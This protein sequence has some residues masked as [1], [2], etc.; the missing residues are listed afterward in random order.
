MSDHLGV[1]LGG[2]DV[3]LAF[4]LALEG[5][6][7]LDDAVVDHGQAIAGLVRVGIGFARRAMGGPAG[8]RD[9]DTALERSFLEA[10]LQRPDLAQRT[11]AVQATL[12][13]EDG[14]A[15]AVV[16]TVFEA[17]QALEQDVL[18]VTTGDGADD[19]T[20]ERS[21]YAVAG[22]MSGAINTSTP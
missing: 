10:A 5:L 14:H 13:G 7:I 8:V 3:A 21:P 20:H 6:V 16:A 12:F 2:E 11:H 22:S 4:Q 17:V 18:D 15:R 1:R 19:A 9:A